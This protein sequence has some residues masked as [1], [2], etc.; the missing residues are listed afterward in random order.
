MKYATLFNKKTTHQSQ[1]IPGS[2]QVPNSAGGYTW[3]VN[4]WALLDRF[5]I[6]GSEAG[7]FY[8]NAPALTQ[9]NAQ[10]VI[11][12]I[13][14]D[15]P[16]VVETIVKTSHSGRAP[17][18]D[19]AI[20]A[21]A[22]CASFGDDN[23]R[24]LALNSLPQVCRTGTHLFQFAAAVDG[25]RGWGRGLRSAVGRWYNSQ[26]AEALTYQL[27]KY[28]QREG[29]S[30]RDLLRLAHPKPESE[31]HK[32]LYKWVVDDEITEAM[33]LVEAVERLKKVGSVVEAAALIREA[34][35][36]REAVPTELL[37]QHGIWEALLEDM[38]LTAMIRNLGN[39]SKCDLLT[40]SSEAT[41]VVVRALGDAERL[42]K[43]RVHPV[44]LLLAQKTY[45]K[46]SGI[47]GSGSWRAVG[48]I[49]DALDDA[50]YKA[51]EFVEPTNKRYLLGLDVS[52]SM[53]SYMISSG[54]LSC[55][56]GAAA[57]ALVT[58]STEDQVSTMAFADTFKTLNLSR[59]MRLDQALRATS[60]INFGATDCA[61]PMVYAMKNKM[62]VDVFVVYTDS[63]TWYGGI[64]PAQ[65]LVE[66]RQKMGIDAKLIVVG[67][68]ANQFSIADPRDRGM[69]DVVGFDSAVPSVMADFAKAG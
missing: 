10:N 47:R 32:A 36:P 45:A 67:M 46:G 38:P 64:H 55:A 25:L 33:P 51:F 65:A 60:G 8:I 19:P 14:Q 11:K 1:P 22:L 3:S 50:F 6:L 39:M 5:L 43:A 41:K 58:V 15:G 17:K 7:T 26:S 42:R 68:A 30:H 21:L 9:S 29:W 54:V 34:R 35:I 48:A 12:L 16:R 61:L 40:P 13:G 62:P 18:N 63:E 49:I 52:G 37:T 69:L 24:A 66:Y 44:A 27:V 56:E 23:T 59:K 53:G 2:G 31:Q 4:D 57:M 28:M 20:F